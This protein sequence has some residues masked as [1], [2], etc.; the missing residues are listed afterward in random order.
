MNSSCW[1]YQ[2]SVLANLKFSKQLWYVTLSRGIKYLLFVKPF[3]ILK[4]ICGGEHETKHT[5]Q[6]ILNPNFHLSPFL[7]NAVSQNG[8]LNL[9]SEN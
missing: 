8:T 5:T 6:A 1:I 3:I 2:C 9:L 4:D 7:K